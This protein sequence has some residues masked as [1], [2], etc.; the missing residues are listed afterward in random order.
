MNKT[1]GKLN[2]TKEKLN[3]TEGKLNITEEKLEKITEEKHNARNEIEN[4]K[5]IEDK[6]LKELN[7][8]KK[9]YQN[10]MNIQ[11]A[12]SRSIEFLQTSLKEQLKLSKHE[13]Q[14]QLE[15]VQNLHQLE[16]ESILNSIHP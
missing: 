3:K 12:N 15:H 13:T 11:E 10:L 4:L 6:L 2:I 14:Q 7:I 16:I 5:E 1:E 9:E 8:Y